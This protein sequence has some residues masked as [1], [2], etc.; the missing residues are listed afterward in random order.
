MAKLVYIG[1]KSDGFLFYESSDEIIENNSLL[2]ISNK[3]KSYFNKLNDRKGGDYS[4]KIEN[5]NF[6]IHYKIIENVAYMTITSNSYSQKLAFCFL[7][8]LSKI[9]L[10]EI[11]T[12]YGNNVDYLSKLEVSDKFSSNKLGRFFIKKIN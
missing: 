10:N 1:R 12:M 11:K 9:F 6:M 3:S 2:E 8:E 5:T 7:E 4:I